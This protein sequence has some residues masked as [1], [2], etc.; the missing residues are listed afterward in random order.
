MWAKIVLCFVLL[1]NLV[2]NVALAAPSAPTGTTENKTTGDQKQSEDPVMK[3]VKAVKKRVEDQ[4]VKAQ[5]AQKNAEKAEKEAD[6]ARVISIDSWKRMKNAKDAAMKAKEKTNA[7]KKLKEA[8]QKKKIAIDQAKVAQTAADRAADETRRTNTWTLIDSPDINTLQDQAVKAADEAQA[9]ADAAQTAADRATEAV[10][11]AQEA[12]DKAAAEDPYSN[13]NAW[14]LGCYANSWIYNQAK[15]ILLAVIDILKAVL[16]LDNISNDPIVKSLKT[17]FS[18]LSWSFLLLFLVYQSV[19]ILSLM[20]L[21]EDYSE[22]KP[23]IRK[24]V[25]AA[26]LISSLTWICDHL[27]Y[28]GNAFTDYA[29]DHLTK[30]QA[31]IQVLLD[32][33][34]V[35]IAGYFGYFLI[36]LVLIAVFCI[37]ILIQ[38]GIRSAEFAFLVI[39]GPVAI[40]TLVNKEMNL[41]SI[42]WRNLLAI[43][44]TQSIQ[45]ILFVLSIEM[46]ANG[47][48]ANIFMT[49]GF[50]ALTMRAPKMVNEWFKASS[51]SGSAGDVVKSAANYANYA[52]RVV[53]TGGTTAMAK[54]L[55]PKQPD[56][57]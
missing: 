32:I 47:A 22:I 5:E 44:V 25:I 18:S 40:V 30:V 24:T 52:A 19:K 42:W 2:G 50:L 55:H 56:L 23:L 39:I 10:E 36:L 1:F 11:K 34:A 6:N 46:I 4:K 51:I 41:F 33:V 20:I 48:L 37:I 54:K 45:P 43:I 16:N 7:E 17:G 38:I 57:K 26:W 8:Q 53:A 13:C 35:G 21:Q 15:G 3:R 49:I 12:A 9:A 31:S 14:E 27:F 29:L 28:L